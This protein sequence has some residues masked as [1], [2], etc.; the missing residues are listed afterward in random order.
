MS[1]YTVTVRHDLRINCTYNYA[2][3]SVCWQGRYIATLKLARRSAG[4]AKWR[5]EIVEF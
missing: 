2:V 5:A 1:Y 4:C 3:S